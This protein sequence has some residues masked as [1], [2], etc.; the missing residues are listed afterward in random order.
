[1]EE[2][3]IAGK[4]GGTLLDPGAHPLVGEEEEETEIAGKRG[5]HLEPTYTF[6]ELP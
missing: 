6:C 5:A 3:E 4:R 2:T 1:M